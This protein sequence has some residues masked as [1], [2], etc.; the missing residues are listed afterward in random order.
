MTADICAI[1]PE[2]FGSVPIMSA[3]VFAR[4]ILRIEMQVKFGCRLK[5]KITFAA[6][7]TDILFEFIEVVEVHCDCDDFVME[8]EGA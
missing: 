8:K 6:S 5:H 4:K 3:L 1:A 2:P 7:Q